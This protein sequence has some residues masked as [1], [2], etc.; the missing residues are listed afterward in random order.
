QALSCAIAP[1]SAGFCVLSR[2]RER[3]FVTQTLAS[4]LQF[5]GQLSPSKAPARANRRSPA[6]SSRC[7]VAVREAAQARRPLRAVRG[8]T[9]RDVRRAFPGRH[10]GAAY[11][12]AGAFRLFRLRDD[13]R[14]V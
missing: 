13:D 2:K 3:L 10:P 6:R 7:R 11:L 1:L 5:I 4:P 8:R 14:A 12:V 9:D